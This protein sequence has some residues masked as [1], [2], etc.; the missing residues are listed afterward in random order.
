VTSTD[1]RRFPCEGCG[2]DLEFHIG[3][4]RLVCPHCGFSKELQAIEGV[5]VSERGLEEA[6]ARIAAQ[7]TS[8]AAPVAPGRR[9]FTCKAC[10]ATIVFE[11]A[12]TGGEC[13]YCGNTV[14]DADV[15]AAANRLP[16]DGL[17]PFLVEKTQAQQALHAWVKSL[18]FAPNEFKRRGVQGKFNG[19][20]LPYWTFDAMTASR[21]VG[22]RGEHYWVTVGSGKN[23]RRERRTRW[24]HA[25][26]SFQRF[27]DDVPVC[28]KTGLPPGLVR[29]LE[30]WPLNKCIPFNAEALAGYAA[31]TY[32]QELRAG[33]SQASERIRQALEADVRSRIGGDEQRIGHID[34]RY[35]ALTYKHLLL[36]VWMLAYAWNNKTYQ[37]I[38]N[39]CNGDV[40]GERPYSWV[41][42]AFAV[43]MAATLAVVIILA[44]K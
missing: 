9:E 36:P 16:V 38:V 21:Y 15:H 24:Y 37:I 12:M 18:W 14:V 5:Q 17:V 11:G 4:Q 27:F 10:A 7:R 13:A 25:S 34:T 3:A 30:P 23:Q 26:G 6:L 42:I 8:A 40:A 19:L 28:A 39:A 43:L 35:G 32:D 2:A 44:S 29:E 1:V 20:Y 41:K 22:E 33:F 31:M